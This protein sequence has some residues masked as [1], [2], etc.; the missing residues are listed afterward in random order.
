MFKKQKVLDY[1]KRLD[2][3]KVSDDTTKKVKKPSVA[4]TKPLLN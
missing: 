2:F 1:V 4:D 3:I